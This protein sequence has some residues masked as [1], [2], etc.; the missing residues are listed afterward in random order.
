MIL[1]LMMPI[2]YPQNP[3]KG[4]E[5]PV[6]YLLTTYIALANPIKGIESEILQNQ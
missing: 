3:I 6:F 2:V 5:S 1:P 4:I